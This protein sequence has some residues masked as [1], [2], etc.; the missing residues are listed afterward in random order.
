MI[1]V[2]RER[3]L[4]MIVGRDEKMELT[5][6]S[7]LARERKEVLANLFSHLLTKFMNS[8]TLGT[9]VLDNTLLKQN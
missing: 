2:R 6:S 8:S 4:I 1:E 9:I 3:V 5:S 7:L